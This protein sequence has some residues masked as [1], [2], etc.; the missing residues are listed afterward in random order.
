MSQAGRKGL[1]ILLPKRKKW[2]NRDLPCIQN[3]ESKTLKM[4]NMFQN[5]YCLV[6]HKAYNNT[7]QLSTERQLLRSYFKCILPVL[8]NNQKFYFTKKNDFLKK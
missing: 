8:Y 5:F 2:H 1:P 4:S 6:L 3:K 7:K